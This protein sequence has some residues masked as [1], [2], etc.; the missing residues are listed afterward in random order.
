MKKVKNQSIT[1]VA[2]ATVL[3]ALAL[4]SAMGQSNVSVFAT[5]LNT[6]LPAVQADDG[7]T[8]VGL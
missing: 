8:I 6:A 1:I 7:H 3:G 4:V 5:E 2:L